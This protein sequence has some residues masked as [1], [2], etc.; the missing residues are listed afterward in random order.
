MATPPTRRF[1]DENS[2][3]SWIEQYTDYVTY[4][5]SNEYIMDKIALIEDITKEEADLLYLLWEK[6]PKA[7][8]DE[9]RKALGY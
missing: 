7:F 4:T 3:R 6:D 2:D 5:E 1:F 9:W 8:W